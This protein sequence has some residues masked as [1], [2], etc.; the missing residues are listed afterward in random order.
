MKNIQQTYRNGDPETSELASKQIL[1]NGSRTAQKE[2]VLKMLVRWPGSRR[3]TSAE[4]AGFNRVDRHMVARRLP[5]LEA[6][7]LVTRGEKKQCSVT[8]KQAITWIPT[9]YGKDKDRCLTESN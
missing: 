8:G 7:G 3:P 9:P 2:R 6:D 4:L 5:D 1:K